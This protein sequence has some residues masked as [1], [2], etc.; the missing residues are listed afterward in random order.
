[1][2][3]EQKIGSGI[4]V[5]CLLLLALI[6]APTIHSAFRQ[7][8]Q[9]RLLNDP[10]PAVRVAALRAAGNEG[11]IEVL[12][13]G[14]GD[15]NSDVR[16]VAAMYL[17][18]RGKAAAPSTR[19]L[20]AALKDEHSWVRRE[21]AETLSGIGADAVPDLVNALSDPDPHVRA[22]AVMGLGD[23]PKDC[24]PR[25]REEWAMIIPAIEKLLADEDPEVRQ[26]AEAFLQYHRRRP[27]RQE[28]GV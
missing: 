17:Q 21:V 25:S 5:G 13:Q 18:R 23:R 9:R 6:T 19:A 11:H 7:R 26:Q 22:G 12:T 4:A 1:M 2:T 28:G 20:I 16:F 3:T 10:N 15:A 27:A 14:L 24:R 8:E